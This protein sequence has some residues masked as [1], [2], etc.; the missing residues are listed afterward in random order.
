MAR[1]VSCTQAAT[2]FHPWSV[3][4]CWSGG[5]LGG[6]NASEKE[7]DC[8]LLTPCQ[9]RSMLPLCDSTQEQPQLALIALC[10]DATF[11]RV[12]AIT[13]SSKRCRI[14]STPRCP[15][16]V[17]ASERPSPQFLKASLKE[18]SLL[19]IFSRRDLRK[20]RR[21]LCHFHSVGDASIYVQFGCMI[22]S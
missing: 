6:G 17:S 18:V 14:S 22:V 21:T 11:R 13:L 5:T 4:I 7:F 8:G 2:N 12:V 9:S 15:C 19:L 10:N 20:L 1:L 16:S 3:E